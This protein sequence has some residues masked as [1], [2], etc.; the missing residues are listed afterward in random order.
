MTLAPKIAES[1]SNAVISSIANAAAPLS[2]LYRAQ[3]HSPRNNTAEMDSRANRKDNPA[4]ATSHRAPAA[5]QSGYASAQPRRP[6]T[7]AQ[8]V[9]RERATGCTFSDACPLAFRGI[10]RR[11]SGCHLAAAECSD[12]RATH[13]QS[14]F[15]SG[16]DSEGQNIFDTRSN[17]QLHRA[18]KRSPRNRS[19]GIETNI[20]G[21]RTDSKWW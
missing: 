15:L 12:T 5:I 18:S 21:H 10:C 7:R 3:Q 11:D 6:S 13:D 17:G 16:C 2:W 9:P 14:D 8:P 4:W 20:A 19:P 1:A